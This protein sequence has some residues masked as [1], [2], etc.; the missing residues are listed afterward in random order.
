MEMHFRQVIADWEMS[1]LVSSWAE[2]IENKLITV[3][4]VMQFIQMLNSVL[5]SNRNSLQCKMCFYMSDSMMLDPS[6]KLQVY[7]IWQK[8]DFS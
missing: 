8:G 3:T 1:N 2:L 6:E 4:I 5:P 7:K